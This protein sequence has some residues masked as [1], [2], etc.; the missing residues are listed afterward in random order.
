M[1]ITCSMI[2]QEKTD[3]VRNFKNTIRM[4]ITNPMLFGE[5]NIIFGYERVFKN[6]QSITA[7]VGRISF[8]KWKTF[9][10]D[11]ISLDADY[12]DKGYTIA[13]DYRFY[14][15]KENKY[16][17]PRGV[18]LGPY[19]SFNYFNRVNS[20]TLDD[21]ANSKMLTTDITLKMNLIGVQ[22]GYQFVLWKR[23]AIDLV[24][25]GPGK[26]FYN[27]NVDMNTNLSSE[28]EQLVFDKINEAIDSKVPGNTIDIKPFEISKKGSTSS[29]TGGFRYVMHLGFRF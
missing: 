23:L 18:Y 15:K 14:L 11:S 13:L 10:T 17:A 5:R 27:I 3:S 21:Q 16:E 7:N 29:S 24:L 22:L 2:G 26:W 4:N 20:W 6:N 19:Y 12:K 28:D 8:P 25:L 1:I 9:N